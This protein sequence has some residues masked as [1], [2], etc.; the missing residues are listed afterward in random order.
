MSEQKM[1]ATAQAQKN[2]YVQQLGSKQIS[3][4]KVVL[5][6]MSVLKETVQRSH[7]TDV[8]LVTYQVCMCPNKDACKIMIR[9]ERGMFEFQDKS[10]YTLPYNHLM[11]CCFD[12]NPERIINEY[13]EAISATSLKQSTLSTAGFSRISS[14]QVKQD[15]TMLSQ[16]DKE[17]HD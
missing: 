3:K 2:A 5:A 8:K 9:G 15:Y 13:W 14:V 1:S 17:L 11:S 6:L 12:K 4:E 7:K 16:K 10:G